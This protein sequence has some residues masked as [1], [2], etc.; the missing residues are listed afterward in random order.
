[1]TSQQIANL[2]GRNIA[3][4]RIEHN[5]SQGALAAKVGLSRESLSRIENGR[6][7]AQLDLLVRIAEVLGCPLVA[8][9]RGLVEA[10]Q[11]VAA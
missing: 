8:L 9:L 2:V 6:Q 4:V 5:R 11:A 7:R 10:E 1:M 3:T